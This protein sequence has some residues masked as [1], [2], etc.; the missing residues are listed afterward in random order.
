MH[1]GRMASSKIAALQLN[2]LCPKRFSVMLVSLIHEITYIN[3]KCLNIA[4]SM[5]H[6]TV[7]PNQKS[8]GSEVVSVC[9]V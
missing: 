9:R 2:E 5:S 6:F 7:S 3:E 8:M 4:T 1:E